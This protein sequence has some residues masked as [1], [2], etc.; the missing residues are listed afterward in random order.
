MEGL[1][2]DVPKGRQP[3]R[4]TNT[5]EVSE[6]KALQAEGDTATTPAKAKKPWIRCYHCQKK[7]HYA[8]DCP[9]LQPDQQEDEQTQGATKQRQ[10][11][12]TKQV[13]VV[14]SAVDSQTGSLE[15]RIEEAKK[16]Y[17]ELQLERL[18]LMVSPTLQ[19]GN[20]VTVIGET[21]GPRPYTT[22]RI[23]GCEVEAMLDTDSPAC[24]HHLS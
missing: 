13:S 2:G 19:E 16:E 10:A 24:V 22:V 7:D 12:G 4:S 11:I 1:P 17:Q 18:R 14:Q 21:V 6:P 8:L 23:E 20:R 9:A 15:E 3:S 5:Q